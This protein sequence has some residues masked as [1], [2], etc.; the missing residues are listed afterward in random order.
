M[1]RAHA[2][3]LVGFEPD[4][5]AL[6]VDGKRVAEGHKVEPAQLVNAGAQRSYLEDKYRGVVELTTTHVEHDELDEYEEFNPIPDTLEE[7]AER[8]PKAY[9]RISA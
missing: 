1:N 9:E 3:V 6:Y 2:I 8:A 5:Q 7:L 4:W